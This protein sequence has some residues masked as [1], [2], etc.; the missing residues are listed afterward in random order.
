MKDVSNGVLSVC[1]APLCSRSA[2]CVPG[3]WGKTW[4][5]RDWIQALIIALQNPVSSSMAKEPQALNTHCQVPIKKVPLVESSQITAYFTICPRRA[6]P[7]SQAP[8]SAQT[9]SFWFCWNTRVFY[10][11]WPTQ[12][13]L[14]GSHVNSTEHAVAMAAHWVTQ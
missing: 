13:L 11:F 4:I 10:L 1:E 7:D 6:E 14:A 2:C 3:L 12:C 5:I 9:V 8:T